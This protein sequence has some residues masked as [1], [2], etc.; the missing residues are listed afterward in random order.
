MKKIKY[1]LPTLAVLMPELVFASNMT[2]KDLLGVIA[3]YLDLGLKVLMGFAVLMFVYNIVQLFIKP[4][5]DDRAEAKQ[6][7]LW[8]V[9]GFFVILSFWGIVNVFMGTFSLDNN[10]PT[11]NTINNIIPQ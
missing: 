11:I 7:L 8:S 4:S 1:I 10:A 6:Y 9:I 2:L 3:G 5:G